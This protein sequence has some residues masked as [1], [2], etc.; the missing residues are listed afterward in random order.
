MVREA[1]RD[2]Y[3]GTDV[4]ADTE[5]DGDGHRDGDG[6]SNEDTLVTK[7]YS[8]QRY[9]HYKDIIIAKI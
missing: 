6:D 4:N 8:S 9:T 7:I 5:K 3:T 2:A 1:G